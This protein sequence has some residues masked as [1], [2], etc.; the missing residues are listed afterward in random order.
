ML[1][2]DDRHCVTALASTCPCPH[3]SARPCSCGGVALQET[4]HCVSG[5][6]IPCLPTASPTSPLC[7]A[8]SPPPACCFQ[9]QLQIFLLDLLPHVCGMLPP[10]FSS[11]VAELL[12]S[13]R[14]PHATW[15]FTS[16][17]R[18]TKALGSALSGSPLYLTIF[19]EQIPRTSASMDRF[20][21]QLRCCTCPSDRAKT[22]SCSV[23]PAMQQRHG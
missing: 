11:T 22:R 14:L 10:V 15:P 8:T 5:A 16:G 1:D 12:H 2:L 6:P 7:P 20:L 19:S 23:P 3:C 18:S 4:E 21:R 13:T 17:R 9:S